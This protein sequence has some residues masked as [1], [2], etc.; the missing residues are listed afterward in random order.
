MSGYPSSPPEN[1][2]SFTSI[3]HTSTYPYID[4]KSQSSHTGRSIFISGGNRGIGKAVAISF[5]QAGASFIGLGCNDGFSSAKEDIES[6]AREAGRSVPKVLCL[7]LDVTDSTSVAA[8]AATIQ[9]VASGLDVLVNNAGFM[10]TALPVTEADEELWWKTL[11]V[12]LKGVFLMSK[13]FTPLLVGKENGLKTMVNI[14]SVAAHNL[15][16]NASAYG[17]S[18]WSV[19]KFTEFLLVEQAKQGLLAFSIH[20]GAIMTE[21]A[22]AMPK[23]THPMLGDKPELT[24]DTVAFLTQERREWLAGRYLSCNWDMEEFLGREEEIVKGDKLKLRL[25]I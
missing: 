15:R 23:E 11:E 9:S 2:V 16:P 24:G 10:T 20:P 8:A 18:K 17:I 5:S 7:H 25:A 19:L 3:L 1:G 21:L 14:N 22:R 12:N 13:H 6:A 4:S